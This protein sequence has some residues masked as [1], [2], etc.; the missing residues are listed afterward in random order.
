MRHARLG[1]ISHMHLDQL[2]IYNASSYVLLRLDR[3]SLAWSTLS[4]ADGE[5]EMDGQLV[6]LLD[7]RE[8]AGTTPSCV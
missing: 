6:K 1:L 7:P 8:I 3:R 4:Q 5:E 2:Q